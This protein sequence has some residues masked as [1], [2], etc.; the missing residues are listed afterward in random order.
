MERLHRIAKRLY[1]F[2]TSAIIL[3]FI[4]IA[5]FAAVTLSDAR[6]QSQ[7]WLF[8]SAL[9]LMWSLLLTLFIYS[10]SSVIGKAPKGAN[11]FTKIRLWLLSGVQKAIMWLFLL[12]F[13]A[14]VLM[15]FRLINF[16]FF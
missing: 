15:T 7:V 3:A 8:A 1:P 10:F 13:F 12:V 11:I 9:L 14:S 4:A 6:N 5:L 16:G 2:R